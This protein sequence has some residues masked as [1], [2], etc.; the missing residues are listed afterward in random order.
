MVKTPYKSQASSSRAFSGGTGFG[1]SPFGSSPFGRASSPFTKGPTSLISYLYEP[2]DLS[3]I[4]DPAVVVIFKNL[5]KKDSTTKA[6]AL[7]DLQ[8]VLTSLEEAKE[9]V[10]DVVLEAWVGLYQHSCLSWT[11]EKSASPDNDP[12]SRD[13]ILVI[14][15]ASRFQN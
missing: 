7:E 3:G 2:P 10:E 12:T 14:E 5:Q 4:S 9:E 13:D 15:R 8:L 11:T 6:K 1:G